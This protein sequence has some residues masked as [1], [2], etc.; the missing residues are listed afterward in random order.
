MAVG[1]LGDALAARAGTS[2]E[3]LVTERVLTPLGMSD[4]RV[5][6]PPGRAHSLLQGHSPRGRP[7]PPIEDFMPAAGALRSTVEDMLR[8]LGA[9]LQ[10]PEGSL[11]RALD[12]AQRPHAPLG[13]GLQMGLCWVVLAR[14]G[15]PRVVWHSGGTWG[16]RA[17]AGF[18]PERGTAAV[19]LSNTARSVDRLGFHLVEE[20][21]A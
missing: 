2:Y 6:V 11:G 12:L 17:F 7:R 21:R 10:A 13:R 19:V 18:A 15:H 4:T 3:Q 14:R 5:T 16:F 8:F 20:G 1:L 9:C